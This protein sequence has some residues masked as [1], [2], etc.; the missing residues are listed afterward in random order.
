MTMKQIFIVED[1]ALLLCELEDL[2]VQ[3]GYELAGSANSLD[4][5]MDKLTD[6]PMPDLALLDLN[7]NGTP[8]DP[9]ADHLVERGV[10]IIFVSGYGARGL[11]DRF[12]GFDVLQKPYD[13][14]AL[15]AALTRALHPKS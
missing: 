12:T 14:A 15:A 13:E 4:K 6:G 8:S 1:E 5:A 3:L 7:L 9:I 2:V 11:G 10:P